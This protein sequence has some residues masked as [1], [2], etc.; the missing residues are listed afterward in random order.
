M[1]EILRDNSCKKFSPYDLKH[2]HNTS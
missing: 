1:A 2:S